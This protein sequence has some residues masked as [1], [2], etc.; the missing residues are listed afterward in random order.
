MGKKLHYYQ[1]A[2]ES[3]LCNTL[4]QP[5][6]FAILVCFAFLTKNNTGPLLWRGTPQHPACQKRL[7][8]K[9]WQHWLLA[10]VLLSKI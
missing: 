5:I 8:L 3:G 1:A 6:S 2:V 10:S 4:C 9:M 7:L